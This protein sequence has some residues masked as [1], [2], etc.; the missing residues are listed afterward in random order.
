MNA[1]DI[2]LSTDLED[3]PPSEYI[4]ALLPH[5]E[6]LFQ[7]VEHILECYGHTVLNAWNDD[8][9]QMHDGVVGHGFFQRETPGEENMVAARVFY[10]EDER[11]WR[12]IAL[13]D[14]GKGGEGE[15]TASADGTAASKAEAEQACDLWLLENGYYLVK[16]TCV[17]PDNEIIETYGGTAP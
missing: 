1:A 3:I 8:L 2:A 6:R 15:W 12:W 7:L 9:D 5:P 13:S 10:V 14:N 16:P 17:V 11:Q 4:N